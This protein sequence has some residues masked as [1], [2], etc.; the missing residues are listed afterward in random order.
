M[1]YQQVV[2]VDGNG[3]LHY[4]GEPSWSVLFCLDSKQ[5][6]FSDRAKNATDL[7]FNKQFCIYGKKSDDII[8][9]NSNNVINHSIICCF[10]TMLAQ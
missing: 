3:L 8:N 5:D 1:P 2:F 6:A 7:F 9:N 4:R 10:Y